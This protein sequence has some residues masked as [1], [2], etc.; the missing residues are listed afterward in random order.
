MKTKL[1]ALMMAVCLL[2]GLVLSGCSGGGVDKLCDYVKKNG[3]QDE[4][5][6]DL[7]FS[8]SLFGSESA[9]D[10][11]FH[12]N[13]DGDLSLIGSFTAYSDTVVIHIISG[14]DTY[15]V[16]LISTERSGKAK[17]NADLK[18]DTYNG[19]SYGLLNAVVRDN[20][21]ASEAVYQSLCEEY[22]YMT[23]KTLSTHLPEGVTMADL[24]FAAFDE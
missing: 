6:Y 23:I 22:A 14:A 4:N 3:T 13:D 8:E 17:V 10:F 24:G 5:G 2:G 1:L 16:M 9:G 20:N 19:E 12:V 7:T 18:P 21:E 11:S 15:D